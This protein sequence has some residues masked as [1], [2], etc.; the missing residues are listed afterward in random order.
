[1]TRRRQYNIPDG[2]SAS[3][4]WDARQEAFGALLLLAVG[5]RSLS[6]CIMICGAWVE[7]EL[8][9]RLLSLKERRTLVLQREAHR[10]FGSCSPSAFL[11][12]L[13]LSLNQRPR[14]ASGWTTRFNTHLISSHRIPGCAALRSCSTPRWLTRV[15]TIRS[16]SETRPLKAHKTESIAF[17]PR[18]IR[19]KQKAAKPTANIM[20]LLSAA[21]IT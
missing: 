6:V 9:E 1:M 2:F 16:R 20:M 10:R 18:S 4:Q 14:L 13:I 7:I 8:L 15:L 5:V 17:Y 19:K 12:S 11:V 21:Q 3:W